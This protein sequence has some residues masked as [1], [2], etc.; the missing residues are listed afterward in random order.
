[1]ARRTSGHGH[2]GGTGRGRRMPPPVQARGTRGGSSGGNPNPRKRVDNT[3]GPRGQTSTPSTSGSTHAGQRTAA[4]PPRPRATR[5]TNHGTY[6]GSKGSP[7]IAQ[8]N[9]RARNRAAQAPPPPPPPPSPRPSKAADLNA[10][11]RVGRGGRIAIGL[12]AAAL[13]ISA[14]RSGSSGRQGSRQNQNLYRG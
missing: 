5:S 4:P 7:T 12:G 11:R 3:P 8:T 9:T 13:G 2:S 1:M 10:A 14:F 6:G